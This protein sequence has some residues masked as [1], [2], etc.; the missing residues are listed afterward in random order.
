MAAGSASGACRGGSMAVM[1]SDAGRPV[2][3]RLLDEFRRWDAGGR[4][5]QSGIWWSRLTWQ[6]TLPEHSDFLAGLPDCLDRAVVAVHGARAAAGGGEAVRA[7][8]TAMVWGY[9]RIGYGAFRTARVLRENEH[10]AAV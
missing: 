10:A 6:S 4:R 7:F 9:G 8:V 2:P 1:S 3:S 5:P